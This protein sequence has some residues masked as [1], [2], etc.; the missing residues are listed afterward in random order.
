M[1]QKV[2][3]TGIGQTKTKFKRRDVNFPELM[4]EAV[5]QALKDAELEADDIDCVIVGS[6]PEFFEGMNEPENWCSDFTLGVLKPHYRIHTG[7]TVGGSVGIA[8]YYQVRS[9]LYNN[10]L[11]VS[12]DKL[13]E[14]SVQMGLSLVYSPTMGRDF[15]AG[16]PSAVANQTRIYMDN[17]PDINERHLAKIGT[18]MRKNALNNPYAALKL[19]QISEE[20]MLNMNWLSTP[21]RLLDSCPTSDAA[22]A[23][24]LQ[25]EENA[26]KHDKPVAWIQAV[27][28]IAEGVN[29][30]D[31]D[32][33]HPIALYEAARRIYKES[34]ITDPLEQLD[35][36]ELYDA[37]T[38]QEMIWSE[39]L[40]LTARG[41]GHTLVDQK[42]SSM[43][44][45]LPIN[46]SGGVLSNNSIGASA[47][48]RQAEV[49]L[50]IMNRA[51][52]RQVPGVEVGLAH[53]WGGAIQFHVLM[54]LSSHKDLKLKA[55]SNSSP[56]VRISP[57]DQEPV[58]VQKGAKSAANKKPPEGLMGSLPPIE[59]VF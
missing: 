48:L 15:A 38:N 37:F 1:A 21:F 10:V 54:L 35:V 46:P 12:G 55:P 45:K 53:G 28:T 7:G 34:G 14:T 8:G 33:S 56:G 11:V 27:S 58:L 59:D 19:P 17:F 3:I 52:D 36:I 29:Y 42:T 2:A 30:M 18:R 44:G 4:G 57:W 31:R 50:Q 22:C 9:G 20:M 32:W 49:A 39:G 23:M 40:G 26:E 5:E 24:V 6:S 25:S 47:M 51:G 41:K 43:G 13:S 16:A